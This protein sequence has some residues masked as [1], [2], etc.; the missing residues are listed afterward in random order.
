L[1]GGSPYE[2][3]FQHQ[4]ALIGL[5][6]LPAGNRFPHVT[7]FFSRD[8]VN[9]TEDPSGWIFAQGGPVYI[10]FRPLAPGTWK[11][12]DWTG[13]LR[14]GAGGWV[15][16][17]FA[18]WGSGHRCFVSDAPRNGYVVQVAAVRDFQS[19]AEFQSAVRALPLKFSLDAAPEVTFTSLDGSVLRARYGQTP[20]V[21]G[22]SI[23]Y[24][25]WPL[26]ESPF[27][28]EKR[29]SQKLDLSYGGE[30]LQLDLKNHVRAE[31]SGKAAK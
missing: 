24:G 20:S 15:S 31:I 13:L 29:G 19:F 5:Y 7:T 30:R 9:T 16:T 21:N 6:D 28:V 18:E 25:A 8:L 12:N 3:I 27:A 26:F 2:Q 22:R 1:P 11:P 4:T 14:T 17:G 10:A 23:D